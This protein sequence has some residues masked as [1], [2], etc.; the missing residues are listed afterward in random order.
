MGNTT[1]ESLLER[2]ERHLAEAR[3][4]TMF[5]N[6]FMSV[7]L[8]DPLACQHVLRILTGIPDLI[9]KEIR[10]QHRV[11]KLVSKDAILDIL[12]EDEEGKLYNIEIQRAT[13]VD[14][15]RRTR[16]YG[17]TIDSEYLLKGCEYYEMPDVHVIYISETDLWKSGKTT[18]SVEKHFGGTDIPYDDGMH[19]MYVNAEVNDGTDTANLMKYFLLA[20]PDDM[21]QGELS[22]RVHLL[23]C[24]EGGNGVM[25]EITEKWLQ[26]GRE[27]GRKEGREEG[28]K[29]GRE[30]GIEVGMAAFILD[31]L[32]ENIP[33][34]RILE[35]LQRRFKLKEEAAREYF[36]KY[37][38]VEG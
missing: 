8:D 20:D 12:A 4:M 18:Y 13:D 16:F 34:Q 5:S 14:H 15:A 2:H 25:C 32:E 21:S 11:S 24:E 6:T 33:K 17:A 22:Q 38:L 36:N 28:K 1:Q 7:A 29:E 27:E 37:A 3:K 26:E 23:K 19:V 9:V 35:K 30:E 31:N 10:A